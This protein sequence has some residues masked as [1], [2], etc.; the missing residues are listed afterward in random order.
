[1]P[2][3][4][5]IVAS[6][7][8]GPETLAVLYTI[9]ANSIRIELTG[10]AYPYAINIVDRKSGAL[11]LVHPHNRS[12][13]RLKPDA[14]ADIPALLRNSGPSP[15]LAPATAQQTPQSLPSFPGITNPPA[16]PGS[17]PPGIGPQAGPA[18]SPPLG[19]GNAMPKVMPN[20]VPQ[21]AIALLA[22]TN[23][24]ELKGYACTRYDA[25]NQAQ[26]MEIW[27]TDKLL[28]FVP[29]TQNRVPRLGP[30][31][32]ED[33]WPEWLKSRGLF[34]LK[35]SLHFAHGPE[36]FHFEVQSITP[37][38]IDDSE[39]KLFQPPPDYHELEPLPF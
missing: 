30:R 20:M 9:G 26:R 22:T 36:H 25:T 2:F 15:G 7:T 29:Y 5:R 14:N 39:G 17:L 23:K 37:G 38:H 32:I 13:M 6:F 4:G 18:N 27:A 19:P 34:P 33:Q 16:A 8:R 10:S 28:P 35:A 11:T 31:G 1:V 24:T 3:E 12:F 21:E